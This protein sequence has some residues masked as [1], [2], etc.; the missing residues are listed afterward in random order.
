MIGRLADM[1]VA[2]RVAGIV[3]LANEKESKDP[4][5]SL[6]KGSIEFDL[7]SLDDSVKKR[8]WE[9]VTSKS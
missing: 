3:L 9:L 7:Y 2:S 5:L 6:L 8:L 4:L 1:E